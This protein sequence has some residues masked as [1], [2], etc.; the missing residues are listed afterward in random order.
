MKEYHVSKLGVDTNRGSADAPFLTISKAAAV[1]WAGD[2]ITVHEGTYREAVRPSRGGTSNVARITYRAAAGEQVVVKGSEQ[3]TDWVPVQGTVWKAVIPN[4]LFGGYNPY[5][6]TLW[7]DWLLDPAP[8]QEPPIHLGDVYLNGTSFYEAKCLADVYEAK[9]RTEGMNPP[10]TYRPEKIYAPENTIYQWYAQVAEDVTTI[11]ANFHAVDPTKECVEINVR[12]TCFYPTTIGCDYIT[13]SGFTFAH[14]A[15][16][17]A[18][19]TSE[20]I[21]MVGAHWSKGWVIENNIL[22]DAKCSA[23]SIGKADFGR[24]NHRTLLAEKPGYQCQMEQ[25]FLGLQRG[26]SKECVGG[27]IIRNN[28]I[29]DC[30]QNGIVGHMGCAFS[31]IYGNHI[32]RIAVKHEYFGYEIAGIKLHAAI[33]VVIEKN[34]IHDTTLGTWLDWQTQGTRISK[35]LYYRNDRDFMVEVSHGPYL[36][37]HNIF[38]SD[39]AIDNVAQ[40]GAYVHNLICGSMRCDAVRDRSTPYHFPHSTQVAGT[41]LV[42][43]GDDRFYHNIFVGGKPTYNPNSFFGTSS[44]DDSPISMPEYVARVAAH[45]NGDQECFQA[46][47]QPV[48]IDGNCYYAGAKGFAN[49]VHKVESAF[50]PAVC[51][52]ETGKEVYVEYAVCANLC[53]IQTTKITGD[54]LPMVRI[55]G[56][57]FEDAEGNPVDLSVDYM[58]AVHSDA[59]CV[60]PFEGVNCGVTRVKVWG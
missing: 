32:Y 40:G 44:Y 30:G 43:G 54:T 51:I 18:P 55:V 19:P 36:V 17:W 48:Y 45:G 27:H 39:Y 35:N 53:N 42:Y 57:A 12:E 9:Q 50:D 25:V 21:A 34:N 33:D 46:V 37:D 41:A 4:T 16:P 23:I 59:P 1:A 28:E 20:Q 15:C 5:Q 60:G 24:E 47:K 22:H 8:G 26:W 49:E 6:E 31:Q 58:G 13:I 52:V 10:W 38:A 56:A 7:G 11:Y 3:I 2:C 14:A 29:Y